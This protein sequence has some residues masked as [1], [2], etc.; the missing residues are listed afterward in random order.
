LDQVS[1]FAD[2]LALVCFIYLLLYV[3][4]SLA[5]RVDLH[6][7]PAV[8]WCSWFGLEEHALV[9]SLKHYCSIIQRLKP[10]RDHH[11][12]RALSI[13]AICLIPRMNKLTDWMARSRLMG[14][15]A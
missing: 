12:V 9:S 14:I 7:L 4:C 15:I 3:D 6:N 8:L 10:L 11:L 2:S 1:D 13:Y 5:R